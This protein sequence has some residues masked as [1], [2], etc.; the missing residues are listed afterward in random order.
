MQ[1]KMIKKLSK[2]VG[3]Y[4]K[5]AVIT[6]VLVTLEA[7]MEIVI[8]LLMAQLIDNG[9]DAGNMGV[10]LARRGN[11]GTFRKIA[12]GRKNKFL[13]NNFILDDFLFMINI[14]KEHI[15]GGYTLHQALFH[16]VKFLGCDYAG[17]G[18]KGK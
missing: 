9:I 17:N 16:F 12:L 15:E 13:G 18:I 11:A 3:E 2:Y 7:L 1:L 10:N 6:P 4:K 8:P 5:Y 14:I